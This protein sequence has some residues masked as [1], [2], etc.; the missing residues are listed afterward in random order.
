MHIAITSLDSLIRPRLLVVAAR[1]A[2]R[3]Y[4][5]ASHLPRALGLPAGQ[6]LPGPNAAHSELLA[7]ER[8]LEHARRMHDASWSA[9]K[10]VM[11]MT[12]LLHESML[13]ATP[14]H[15][16]SAAAAPALDYGAA[17]ST[18]ACATAACA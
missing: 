14:P 17:N 18:R 2:L 1:H 6:I 15:P 12:A 11:V 13:L 7:R 16:P 8:A 4:N 5:R 10:H 3:D 9:A